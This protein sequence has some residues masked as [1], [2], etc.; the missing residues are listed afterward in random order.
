M[1][2]ASV[3][4]AISTRRDLDVGKMPVHELGQAD[5]PAS[6]SLPEGKPGAV[7]PYADSGAGVACTVD[8]NRMRRDRSV[9]DVPGLVNAVDE[10][11]YE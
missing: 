3:R 7:H 5:G 1:H 11:T 4:T 9:G 2:S 8:D 6:H 10:E